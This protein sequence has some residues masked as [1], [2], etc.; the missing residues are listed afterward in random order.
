M[1][2]R[3]TLRRLA[4]A[5]ATI[6][7]LLVPS[8]PAVAA[9]SGCT[10]YAA[11]T[12]SDANAGTETSPKLTVQALVNSLKAGETGCLRGGTYPETSNGYV[13]RFVNPGTTLRS[14][15]GSAPT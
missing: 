10:R 9:D 1:S 2:P 8:A 15:P 3:P 6:T 5:A 12:G 13:A 14:Y 11:R 7:A 4:V